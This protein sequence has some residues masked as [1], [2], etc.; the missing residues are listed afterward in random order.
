MAAMPSVINKRQSS[1]WFSCTVNCSLPPHLLM[2]PS[3]C[4]PFTPWAEALFLA[5]FIVNS[6]PVQQHRM[7]VWKKHDFTL[8]FNVAELYQQRSICG[9]TSEESKRRHKVLDSSI[10][11]LVE[12]IHD[13]TRRQWQC[14]VLP[15][16]P[17]NLE[18]FPPILKQPQQA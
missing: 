2:A 10:S 13:S 6:I 7:L 5:T 14:C 11:L 17:N 1:F 16:I 12:T 9:A 18:R 15:R 8:N 3:S 4:Q